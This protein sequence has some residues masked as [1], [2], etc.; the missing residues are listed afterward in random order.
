MENNH[1]GNFNRKIAKYC[2]NCGKPLFKWWIS[3]RTET[4]VF[5]KVDIICNREECKGFDSQFNNVELKID[6][7]P[8]NK[9]SANIEVIA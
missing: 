7:F 3:K 9:D 1:N 8:E 2:A 4:C 5:V 6:L